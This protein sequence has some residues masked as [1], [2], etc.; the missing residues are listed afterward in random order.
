M[1]ITGAVLAARHVGISFLRPVI[2]MAAKGLTTQTLDLV[3][4]QA[5]TQAA[6]AY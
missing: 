4:A 5:N 2:G 3:F 1:G 6:C